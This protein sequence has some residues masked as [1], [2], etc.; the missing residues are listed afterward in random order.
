M[1]EARVEAEYEWGHHQHEGEQPAQTMDEQRT[2]LGHP[3]QGLARGIETRDER[4]QQQEAGGQAKRAVIGGKM[5]LVVGPQVQDLHADAQEADQYADH[6]KSRVQRRMG[7]EERLGNKQDHAHQAV[8]GVRCRSWQ[9]QLRALVSD[10]RRDE[11]HYHVANVLADIPQE[12]RR[13]AGPS[14]AYHN[15]ARRIHHSLVHLIRNALTERIRW[16]IAI[17]HFQYGNQLNSIHTSI[18]TYVCVYMR[19]WAHTYRDTCM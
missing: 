11:D 13:Q 6:A 15:L 17:I 12:A 4:G 3:R 18:Y 1:H 10:D 19:A 16:V 9:P 7:A 5:L 14:E 2:Y 8:E